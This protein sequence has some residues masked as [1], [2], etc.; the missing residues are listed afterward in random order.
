MIRRKQIMATKKAATKKAA[1]KKRCHIL[2]INKDGS[3]KPPSLVVQHNECVRLLSPKGKDVDMK[4]FV[5]FPGG[6]GGPITIHS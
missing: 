4:V 6:G 5:T 3:V 2:R 1:T